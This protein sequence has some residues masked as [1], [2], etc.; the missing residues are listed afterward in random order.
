MTSRKRILFVAEAVTLAHVGRPIALAAGLDDRS[1]DTFFASAPRYRQFFPVPDDRFRPIHSIDSQQFLEALSKGRPVYGTDTLRRYVQD[2]LKVLR[3]L[4][5]D[6]VV[7]DFRL[8][9]SVSARTLGIPYVNITNAHW[10]PFAKLRFPTPDLP[11]VK[12][13]GLKLGELLFRL[14]RPI[15]FAYHARPLNEVRAEHRLPSLG[16]DVRKVYTDGDLVLYADE[17]GLFLTDALPLNHRFIGPILWSPKVDHPDWW[18]HLPED[19]PVIY[20]TLGSSGQADAVPIVLRALAGLP[21]TVMVATAGRPLSGALPPNALVADYLPGEEAAGRSSVVICNGGSA[22]LYQ[23][24][25][26]GA[27]VLGI[28]SNLDQL[29]TMEA[30]T[31]SGAGIVLRASEVAPDRVQE[32]VRL[33]VAEPRFRRAAESI[34]EAIKRRLAPQQFAEALDNL[35]ARKI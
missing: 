22:T 19:R 13:T 25:A 6:V 31:T 24:L 27:P 18:N 15:A 2:D 11:W 34:R 8:S 23:A 33:L 10:S 30:V 16:R 5:P 28:P 35:P 14:A 3:E 9:L 26:A 1:Y 32:V 20:L 17:P 29:L 21:V 12:L 7:G 4:Q